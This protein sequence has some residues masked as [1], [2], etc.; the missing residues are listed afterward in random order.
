V[1]ADQ[2]PDILLTQD[3]AAFLKVSED[4]ARRLLKSGAI[5]HIKFG[6]EY[7]IY[8]TVFLTWLEQSHG[9]T[10]IARPLTPA[11]RR[12]LRAHDKASA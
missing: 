8:K 7:R 1:T 6:Q 9:M 10:F 3:V 5:P 12:A 2:L 4:R 11:R